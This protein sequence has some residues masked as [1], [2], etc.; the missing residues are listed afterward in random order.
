[1][2]K[3]HQKNILGSRLADGHAHVEQHACHS[4]RSFLHTMGVGSTVGLMLGKWSLQAAT[5]SPLSQALTNLENDRVLVLVQLN[6]GNDGLNTTIPLYDYDFYANVRPRI[7]IPEQ[8][9]IKITDEIGFQP[10][11]SGMKEMWDEGS[12]K[13]VQ[14][15]GYPDSSLSH[16]RGTDIWSAGVTGEETITSG[17]LGRWL[18]R[19]FPD[20]QE[21]PPTDPAAIQI[22]SFGSQVFNGTMSGM[23]VNVSNPD[24]LAEIA[25][26]GELFDLASVPATCYGDEVRFLRTVTNSTFVFAERIKAAFDGGGDAEAYPN[27]YGGLA[28]QL[29]LVARLIKGG[30][31]TRLY[32]VSI[33]SFDTHADQ[34]ADHQNLW[35]SVSQNLQAFYRDLASSDD[36][37]RVL[38]MTFSEFGRRIEEN[39][40]RGTDHGTSAPLFLFGPGLEG[41]ELV[42]DAPDLQDQDR[43]GNLKF[44]TDFRSVYASVLENWL[45]VDGPIVDQVLG[46][47]FA[48]IE[49]LLNGC[50]P[51]TSDHAF[52]PLEREI[53]HRALYS[54]GGDV[55]IEYALRVPAEVQLDVFDLSGRK[56]TSLVRGRQTAGT[57]RSLIS[58]HRLQL[59]PGN[60]AYG[61]QVDGAQYSRLIVLK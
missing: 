2:E 61:L 45:C 59:A 12:L 24:E 26:N 58:R 17:W 37:G 27:N 39:A 1:M 4:R 43:N 13:V 9:V 55:F 51:T 48:R 38:T 8:Q 47:N 52:V 10:I 36:E 15:V 54:G 25:Q 49:G 20:F 53:A 32:M 60:Y 40:S 14:N 44:G 33:G 5:A 41:S 46:G 56:V 28:D 30:L 3:Y 11:M 34:L 18:E 35:N 31:G 50:N 23:A 21:S 6:G 29:A 7:A 57:H 19:E 16:F 22:G 42:G